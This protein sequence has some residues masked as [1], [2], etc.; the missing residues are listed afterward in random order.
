M[1]PPASRGALVRV[2]QTA[3]DR[4]GAYRP[5]APLLRSRRRLW[6]RV[7]EALVRARPVEVR[8]VLAEHA[9][10]LPLAEDEQVV[11]AFAAH[12]PEEALARRVRARS[13]DG[14]A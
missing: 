1:H 3:Q 13:A 4:Y 5:L 10:E 6:E 12:A 2:V 11:E 8:G 14:R 7:P 9:G